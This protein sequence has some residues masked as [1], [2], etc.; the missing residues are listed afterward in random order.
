MEA[1]SS[2]TSKRLCSQF[3]VKNPFSSR[4]CVES[5]QEVHPQIFVIP[6]VVLLLFYII[7]F[8]ILF[9]FTVILSVD[10]VLK[11]TPDALSNDSKDN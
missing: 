9:L 8:I 10:P 2:C 6:F 5:G 7:I 11:D 4:I 1:S 3:Y